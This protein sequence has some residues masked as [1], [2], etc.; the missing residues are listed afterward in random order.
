[1]VFSLPFLIIII[2][3]I[4]SPILS[5]YK[6]I[7]PIFI[8]AITLL[9]TT[10]EKKL[11]KDVHFEVFK[12][13]N[14]HIRDWERGIGEKSYSLVMNISNPEYL[15]FYAKQTGKSYE[16][17]LDVI[18]YGDA[19]IL[20]SVLQ[21]TEKQFLIIGYSGRHTPVQFFN[22]CL[23]YFPYIIDGYQYN[24]SA[25]FLLSNTE[26]ESNS[27]TL[28]ILHS[29]TFS[30]NEDLWQY[31]TQA[32]DSQNKVYK[33]DSNNIYAPQFILNADKALSNN[34][35]FIRIE[36]TADVDSLNQITVVAVPEN[37]NGTPVKNNYNKSIWLG[38]DVEKELI[39]SKKASF[40]FS[41]PPMMPVNGKVKIYI[42]NRNKRH[43]IIKNLTVDVI[44]NIWNN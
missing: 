36:L 29:Y 43:F 28:N 21:Q 33:A 37:E 2:S 6:G 40:A 42:W 12:E 25:I 9:S 22:Q 24:N 20:D 32:Y 10:I 11:F 18:N 5:T 13:L 19:P 16:F 26:K 44:K 41:L 3:N 4:L 31:D 17:D 1:M 14:L 30:D 15:N 35:Q 8:V 23:S 27:S 38:L 34:K 39:A 7:I